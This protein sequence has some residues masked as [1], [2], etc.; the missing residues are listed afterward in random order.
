MSKQ[1]LYMAICDFF[2]WLRKNQRVK[3]ELGATVKINLGSGLA[4][5]NDWWNVDANINTLVAQLPFFIFPIWYRLTGAR[6]WYSEEYFIQQIT[7]HRFVHH[8][9]LNGIP[10][11]NDKVDFVYSSHFFEHF[12]RQ[13]A[14]F[15]AKEAWRVL[16]AGGIIRVCVPDLEIAVNTYL[17]GEKKEA[18]EYFFEKGKSDYFSRHR[19]LYDFTLL[20]ELLEE[21]GFTNVTRCT[22][23]QGQTPDIAVLDNR[24]QQTLFVE[25]MKVRS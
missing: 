12:Y 15:I 20:T 17:K 1:S 18:L 7:S 13:E 5:T 19:Y 2:A 6:N 3:T 22:H 24:P 8:N 25:A 4:V 11:E 9:I 16:K 10:F 14:L 21:A 23:S